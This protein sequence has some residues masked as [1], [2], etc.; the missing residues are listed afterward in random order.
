[1]PMPSALHSLDAID[2]SPSVESLLADFAPC[3][4]GEGSQRCGL[5]VFP[6]PSRFRNKFRS[7]SGINDLRLVN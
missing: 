5:G 7:A 3:Q 1:M 4:P 2:W 6:G